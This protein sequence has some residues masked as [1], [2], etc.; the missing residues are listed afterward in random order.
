MT[1][2][3][4]RFFQFLVEEAILL[5]ISLSFLT[6]SCRHFISPLAMPQRPALGL[7]SDG[8]SAIGFLWLISLQRPLRHTDFR[9]LLDEAK[10]R[11][12]FER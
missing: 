3:R 6:F 9:F 5:G 1:C 11:V 2:L 12:R 7:V 8:S 4:T 10:F